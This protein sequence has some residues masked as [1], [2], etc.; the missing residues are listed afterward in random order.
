MRDSKYTTC[1][2]GVFGVCDADVLSRGN[3]SMPEIPEPTARKSVTLPEGMW[4]AIGEYRFRNRV[5]A[6]AEAIRQLIQRGLE[7]PRYLEVGR[8]TIEILAGRLKHHPG[9]FSAVSRPFDLVDA[10]ESELMKIEPLLSSSEAAEKAKHIYQKAAEEA[11]G[12]FDR[13]RALLNVDWRRFHG[14]SPV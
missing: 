11:G 9:P 14:V 3:R 7:L 4:K 12:D 6:E 13:T 5:P 1:T 10:L 8:A 2:N